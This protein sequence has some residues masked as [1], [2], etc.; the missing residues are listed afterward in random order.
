MQNRYLTNLFGLENLANLKY[1]FDKPLS[2]D[3]AFIFAAQLKHD[4]RYV[5]YGGVTDNLFKKVTTSESLAEK[6]VFL[7]LD[8]VN[9]PDSN[10]NFIDEH[11]LYLG[12]C[13]RHFGHFLV[14]TIARLGFLKSA[15]E[16]D[17]FDSISLL[18]E[19]TGIPAF[20]KE[21]FQL[22][23]VGHKVRFV[24]EDTQFRKVTVLP[25]AI[26]YPNYVS[27]VVNN[28]ANL[29]FENKEN[30]TT[31]ASPIFISRAQ[32]TPGI[33]RMVI[34]EDVI[35]KKLKQQGIPVIFPEKMSLFDQINT[36]RN[37]SVFIGSAGSAFHT[38]MLAGGNKKNIYYSSRKIPS[39]F[40]RI[41][42]VLNNTNHLIEAKI[43]QKLDLDTSL[44]YGFK[45]EIIN[46]FKVL[47]KLISLDVISDYEGELL[48]KDI[49]TMVSQYHASVLLRAIYVESQ[50]KDISWCQEF[51][52]NFLQRYPVDKS[53]IAKACEQVDVFKKILSA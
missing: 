53:T 8:K 36:F 12:M 43:T 30:I 47:D 21:V 14:E 40:N 13:H 51:T 15:K 23:G 48:P 29:F 18:H 3:N 16:L 5:Y 1:R 41:D 37:H 33:H 35:Q 20:A 2:L 9:K 17:S 38:M 44:S 27:N 46:P 26:V 22:L 25:Q 42:Q 10:A 52:K 45:P 19:E 31:P 50:F 34:G 39:I 24:N 6:N 7:G 49:E 11:T 4:R 28:L 32:L